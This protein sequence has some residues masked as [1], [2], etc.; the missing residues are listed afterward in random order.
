MVVDVN[1]C[2]QPVL[3]LSSFI[4]QHVKIFFSHSE[5][6][7]P[8]HQNCQ[9]TR[10]FS[11][12][13]SLT[14][15]TQIS[16]CKINPPSFLALI[17]LRSASRDVRIYSITSLGQICKFRRSGSNFVKVKYIASDDEEVHFRFNFGIFV[18]HTT[19]Y[20]RILTKL[21]VWMVLD[22]HFRHCKHVSRCESKIYRRI[23][24]LSFPW[25]CFW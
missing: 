3:T 25:E 22:K 5:I 19:S 13:N 16:N 23:S 11:Q 1:F 6:G 15:L 17:R 10:L 14:E 4:W 21:T 20:T 24:L 7:N 2:L 9:L 8:S 18:M 12:I